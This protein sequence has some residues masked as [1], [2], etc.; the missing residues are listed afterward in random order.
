[1]DDPSFSEYCGNITS[2]SILYPETSA[3]KQPVKKLLDVAGY[4]TES[5][6]LTNRMLNWI[7][8]VN[9]TQVAPCAAQGETQDEC[10]T[11]HNQTYYD[12]DDLSQSWRS[13][14]YQYCAQ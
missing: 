8:Y 11:T 10:F 2:D 14:P 6:T 9:A 5:A 4:A 1:V 7:G 12:Q 3:L 13:W